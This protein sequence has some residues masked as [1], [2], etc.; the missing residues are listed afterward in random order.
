LEIAI[1]AAIGLAAGLLGGL[2]GI[3][4]SVVLIPALIFYFSWRGEGYTGSSEHLIQAAAMVCNVFVAAPAL[5]A[6]ARAG[7]IMPSVVWRVVPAALV[8]VVAGVT[9]SNTSAFAEANGRYLAM[10]FAVFMG[11]VALYNLWRMVSRVDLTASY[12]EGRPV[13]TGRSLGIGLTMG[14]AGGLLG[15]GGGSVCVPAQQFFL[16]LPLRRAIANSATTIVFTAAVGAVYKNAT[17]GAHGFSAWESLSL[18][19]VLAP[20]AIVGSYVGARL[21][22]CLPRKVLQVVF[23]VFMGFVAIKVMGKAMAAGAIDGP[24]RTVESSQHQTEHQGN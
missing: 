5:V 20:T 9:L 4:G 16:R 11:Y 1:K 2:L 10:L 8:G 22:H 21:V 23:V 14:V 12:E 15:I 13:A 17:L 18:A 19:A 7:A 3:G 6:H 24:G